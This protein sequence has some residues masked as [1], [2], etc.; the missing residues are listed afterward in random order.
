MLMNQVNPGE[1]WDNGS[2]T[3]CPATTYKAPYVS[4]RQVSKHKASIQGRDWRVLHKDKRTHLYSQKSLGLMI[5]RGSGWSHPGDTAS[6]FSRSRVS[7]LTPR[8]TVL[9]KIRWPHKS[10]VSVSR[11]R[12]SE[13]LPRNRTYRMC[14][15]REVY[16]K[17]LWFW[18]L[19][20]L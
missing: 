10:V 6:A 12:I 18:R 3:Y 5:S 16:F 20:G 19:A 11:K 2:Y 7:C 8:P 1:W 15:H 9:Q 13:F 14:K 17:Q 4:G